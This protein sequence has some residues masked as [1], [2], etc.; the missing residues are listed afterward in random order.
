MK[1]DEYEWGMKE[2]M[3][4]KEFLYTNMIRDIYYL[5][6]VL[7]HKYKLLRISYNIFMYGMIIS[8]LAFAAAVIFFPVNN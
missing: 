6:A 4:D 8:V 7:G 2:I 5:G 1:L 3:K